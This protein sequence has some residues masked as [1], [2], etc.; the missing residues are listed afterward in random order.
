MAN[1]LCMEGRLDFLKMNRFHVLGWV[2]LGLAISEL[3]I[4]VKIGEPSLVLFFGF[5]LSALWFFWK[6]GRFSSK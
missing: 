1:R 3:I 5:L 6:A 4:P 2:S